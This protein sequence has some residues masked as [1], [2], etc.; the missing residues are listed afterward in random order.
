MNW[1]ETLGFALVVVLGLSVM[2]K[3]MPA[4]KHPD[5]KPRIA[6]FPKYQFPF[7]DLI[8]LQGNLVSLGFRQ[9][10]EFEFVRGK[11]LGDFSASQIKL[12]VKINP[13]MQIATLGSAYFVIAFDTGDLWKIVNTLQG[14]FS[15]D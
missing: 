9:I 1:I 5:R 2:Y 7:R 13:R 10:S 6:F 15:R 14:P 3:G 8:D 11:M 12:R 4:K